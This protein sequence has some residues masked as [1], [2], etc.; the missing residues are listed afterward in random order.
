MRL[1]KPKG[2]DGRMLDSIVVFAD[3]LG[4]KNHLR[5]PKTAVDFVSK[6]RA[7][8]D[9][10]AKRLAVA[11]RLFKMMSHRWFSDC[12]CLSVSFQDQQ[13]ILE[14]LKIAAQLQLEFLLNGVFL[15][16]GVAVGLHYH[17]EHIDLGPALAEAAELEKV[18]KNPAIF[19]TQ[20]LVDCLRHA[21]SDLTDLVA[22]CQGD[23]SCF[24]NFF[25][26]LDPTARRTARERI[27]TAI[28]LVTI[29]ANQGVDD[30]ARKMVEGQRQKYLWLADYFNYASGAATKLQFSGGHQFCSFSCPRGADFE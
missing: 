13:G 5:D 25:P 7:S 6:I 15:R 19:L 11:E 21:S 22:T 8:S 10:A 17:S 9:A 20:R 14:A 3:A 4:T 2:A 27:T 28:E 23:G 24:L 18:C 12:F 30:D 26:L 16:G 1:K 29:G